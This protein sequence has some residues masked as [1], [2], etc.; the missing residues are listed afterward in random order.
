MRGEAKPPPGKKKRGAD[1]GVGRLVRAE[2]RSFG[3]VDARVYSRYGADC[4][5]WA[6]CGPLNDE[7]RLMSWL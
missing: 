5:G 4:G 2:E 3:A 6:F 7:R 1:E